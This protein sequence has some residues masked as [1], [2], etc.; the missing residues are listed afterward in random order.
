MNIVQRIKAGE[1]VDVDG[2]TFVHDDSTWHVGDLYLAQRNGDPK[3]L[4]VRDFGYWGPDHSIG[5][6]DHA[7]LDGEQCSLVFPVEPA[8]PFNFYECVKVREAEI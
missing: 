3:L 7:T 5:L 4:T 2:I 8:Y 6:Y 1:T